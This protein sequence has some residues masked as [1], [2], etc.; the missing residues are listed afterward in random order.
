MDVIQNK[1]TEK[2]SG[3]LS[4][5]MLGEP[6]TRKIFR[7]GKWISKY[8]ATHSAKSGEGGRMRR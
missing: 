8:A 5:Y 7:V 3:S 1:N 6:R 2:N 4:L